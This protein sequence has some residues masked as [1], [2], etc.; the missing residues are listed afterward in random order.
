MSTKT[1]IANAGQDKQQA[2]SR[3]EGFSSLP[4]SEW[5]VAE[6]QNGMSQ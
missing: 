4:D 1:K 3:E 2:S 5:G 6:S